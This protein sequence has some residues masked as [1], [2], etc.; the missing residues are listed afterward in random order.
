MPPRKLATSRPST[1]TDRQIGARQ[2]GQWPA[3][4]SQTYELT[5]RAVSFALNSSP[6]GPASNTTV[7]PSRTSPLSSLVARGFMTSF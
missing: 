5:D 7:C 4:E 6:D 3:T 1:R 2:L